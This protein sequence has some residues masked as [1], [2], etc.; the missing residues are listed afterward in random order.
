V[1]TA[2]GLC[3]IQDAG[4]IPREDKAPCAD[5]LARRIDAIS[6]WEMINTAAA[7]AKLAG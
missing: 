1:E 6:A 3:G 5:R 2:G 7:Q 4:G